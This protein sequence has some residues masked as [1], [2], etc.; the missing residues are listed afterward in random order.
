MLLEVTFS[1]KYTQER[2][3][4]VNNKKLQRLTSLSSFSSR[5]EAE[6]VLPAVSP[7]LHWLKKISILWM[8]GRGDKDMIIHF[9]CENNV[10]FIK[11][12]LQE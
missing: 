4:H 6:A 1:S 2:W 7:L 10:L 12:D 9:S 5:A 3:Y 8:E 11:V